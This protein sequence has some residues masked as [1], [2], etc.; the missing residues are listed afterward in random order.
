MARALRKQKRFDQ[1]AIGQAQLDPKIFAAPVRPIELKGHDKSS[2]LSRLGQ[3]VARLVRDLCVRDDQYVTRDG[4]QALGN[5]A[6]AA[7]VHAQEVVLASGSIYNVRFMTTGVEVLQGAAWIATTGAPWVTTDLRPFAITGWGDSVVFADDTQGIFRLDFTGAF[8]KTLL[9]FLPGVKHL[10]TF[11]GRIIAS[12]DDRIVWSVR[13]DETDWDGIGSGYEDLRS[14]TGGRPDGQTAVVPISDDTALVIRTDS[15]WLMTQTGDF[16]APFRFTRLD[17]GNGKGCRWPRTVAGAS[18]GALWLG[19]DG[20]VWMYADEKVVDVGRSIYK[21]LDMTPSRLRKACSAYDLRFDEYRLTI[22]DGSATSIVNRF[23]RAGLW[24]EDTYRFPIRSMSYALFGQQLTIDELLG[25][26]DALT[27]AIDDLTGI[28]PSTKIMFA[29]ADPYRYVVLEKK[30]VAAG[31]RDIK[32]DGTLDPGSLRLETGYVRA[33]DVLHKTE[34]L[35]VITEYECDFACT[36]QYYYSDDGGIIWNLL[37]TQA[38]A[39][40]SKPTQL[41]LDYTLDRDNIQ[42]AVVSPDVAKLRFI[43]FFVTARQGGMI[44]DAN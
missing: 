6:G 26:I 5:A 30:V 20:A 1:N 44:I 38:I 29:M 32:Q 14:A 43:D 35:Q 9:N 28:K 12:L 10:A 40:T 27:G 41:A 11:A 24:T 13:D 15:V 22:P 37:S 33:G 8:A 21:T 18:G 42:F 3:G 23:N 25:T 31:S 36:L 39:A 7:L 34:T 16:D 2:A 17:E 4:T 19:D